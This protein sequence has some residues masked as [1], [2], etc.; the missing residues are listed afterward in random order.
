[1]LH[2]EGSQVGAG[3]GLS[4]KDD[5]LA[6]CNSIHNHKVITSCVIDYININLWF[7]YVPTDT[8]RTS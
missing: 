4:N 8:V 1:M 2:L 7:F 5:E 3:A 6:P